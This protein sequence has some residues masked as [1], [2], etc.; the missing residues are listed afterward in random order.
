MLKFYS[1]FS[2]DDFIG[3][4]NARPI[5]FIGL[6]VINLGFFS[7]F[8]LIIFVILK[9]LI[10]DITI[11]F[12]AYDVILYILVILL[13]SL[14]IGII[15]NNAMYSLE[16]F[17]FYN[18]YN[19]VISNINKEVKLIIGKVLNVFRPGRKIQRSVKTNVDS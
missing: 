17:Y 19:A 9:Y 18:F 6:R 2:E 8:G 3:L 11:L 16:K 15:C 5:V 14:F 10:S 4:S 13:S 1:T 12:F 7:I